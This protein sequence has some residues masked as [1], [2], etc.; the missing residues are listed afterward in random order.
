MSWECRV[1]CAAGL[2]LLSRTKRGGRRFANMSKALAE[3]LARTAFIDTLRRCL[4][5]RCWR[6]TAPRRITSCKTDVDDKAT[7]GHMVGGMRDLSTTLQHMPPPCMT[8]KNLRAKLACGP[9]CGGRGKTSDPHVRGQRLGRLGV[10]GPA[11]PRGLQHTLAPATRRVP[12]G[13]GIWPGVRGSSRSAPAATRPRSDTS[14]AMRCG[15]STPW[16][17][18]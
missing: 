2:K 13:V 6:R 4:P 8:A 1:V 11:L 3:R 9:R 16:R 7:I 12:L 17:P 18:P 5:I 10:A 15:T 14:R